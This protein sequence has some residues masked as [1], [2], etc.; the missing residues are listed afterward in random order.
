MIEFFNKQGGAALLAD[1][2]TKKKYSSRQGSRRALLP[3]GHF[4]Y[5]DLDDPHARDA[6]LHCLT[7]LLAPPLLLPL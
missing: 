4:N 1:S 6:F 5:H 2:D 3:S 7:W